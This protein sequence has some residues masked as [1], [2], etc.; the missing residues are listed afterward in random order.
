MI[1]SVSRRSDVPAFYFDWFLNRLRAGW[2]LTR[3]PFR[4]S[5]VSRVPLSPAAVEC[6]VFWSKNPEPMLGKLERLEPYSW[7]IQYTVNP[8]GKDLESRLPDLARRLDTFRALAERVGPDRVIW[9]YSPI[10]LGGAYSPAFHLEA[11]DGLARVLSGH[12]RQ[13]AL[14]IL[15]MYAKIAPRMRALGVRERDEG[16]SLALARQLAGLAANH[17]IEPRLCGG[18]DPRPADIL[19]ASCVDGELIRRLTGKDM[20]FKKDSGQRGVCNCVESVDVGS[21][22]TCLN[23]CAYC[24]ANHS[25]ASALR[26]A[27]G[28][29]PQ[30]PFLCDQ[31]RPDDAV[32]E[33]KVRLHAA[34]GP[35]QLP[36]KP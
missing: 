35:A 8:Y 33:R 36:L 25:H 2:L 4:P 32:T 6:I 14:S 27:A 10:V 7:Y 30:S 22:Q 29:D 21:Y 28:Y 16:Q 26:R 31:S 23:G 24:Y 12:T 18:P 13:C 15:D 11:F 20:S 19:P 3:N 34:T 5:S 17:G 9:R 1:L